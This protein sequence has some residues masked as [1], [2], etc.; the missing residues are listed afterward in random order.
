[1]GVFVGVDVGV[2]VAVGVF[3]GV[4]VGV[5]V[6]VFV[7]VAVGVFVGIGVPAPTTV[8]WPLGAPWPAIPK[9]NSPKPTA[10]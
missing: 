7:G 8:T 1:M 6:G 4:F 10:V 3:V 9:W 2:F 5:T